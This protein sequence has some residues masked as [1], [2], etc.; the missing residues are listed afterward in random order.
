M[1]S[2]R[3]IVPSNEHEKFLRAFDRL[4]IDNRD[5]KAWQA[6]RYAERIGLLLRHV[7]RHLPQRSLAADIGCAQGN[8]GILLAESG[9]PTI[10]VDLRREALLYA[11]KKLESASVLFVAASAENLPLRDGALG[12]VVR[13][14]LLEHCAEPRTVLAEAAR[15]CRSEG[16]VVISTPN[17]DYVR[18]RQPSFAQA[19]RDL[20]SLKATQFR[21][22]GE[23]HLF[24]F[25]PQEL[26]ELVAEAGLSLVRVMYCG[27]ILYHPRLRLLRS[28]APAAMWHAVGRLASCL[29]V[30]RRYLSE[31]LVAVC[32]KP[33]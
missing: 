20:P 1:R 32:R 16:V 24:V 15:C 14:E 3:E 12:A 4:E 6:L 29:P 5:C 31:T 8:V 19:R 33:D 28:I 26:G 18:N 7:R 9:V 30:V 25:R 23:D 27:S 22:A 11:R 17:G 21:A 10:C 2:S 13:G